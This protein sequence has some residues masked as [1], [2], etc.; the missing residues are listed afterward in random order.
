MSGGGG[1]SGPSQQTVTQTNLPEYARPYFE[2][3]MSRAEAVSNQPYQLY[4]GPR[5]ADFNADQNAAF[6]MARDLPGSYQPAM[7]TSQG[8]TT[9]ATL[10]MPSQYTAGEFQHQN[11]DQA[12]A[13]QYMNPYVSTVLDQQLARANTRFAEQRLDRNARAA[14][15]G[16]FGGYRQGVEEAMAE[17]DY[18]TQ[19]NEIEANAL[20]EAFK[21]AQ[22]QFN[23][24]R[25]A[26][27]SAFQANQGASQQQEQLRQ[28][29]LS[30][31]L[32][33]SQQLFNQGAGAQEA[34]L[35]SIQALRDIGLQQQQMDQA[36]LDL[37]QQ[38]FANQQNYDLNQLNFLNSILRGVPIT[39]S[40]TV[41]QYE[42]P[43]PY[44]Q[45]LGLGMNGLALANALGGSGGG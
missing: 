16:V 19:L 25:S 28:A 23:T 29:G 7:Q 45:L 2:R 6:D 38:D 34:D 9:L 10:G 35:R 44:S 4:Q 33:G 43:N 17:R 11:F 21:N 12:A 15:S 41:S 32:S 22:Q 14:R 24:D 20:M 13:D 37:A 42:N 40:T 1:S 18:N 8:L 26:G 3:M 36:S 30:G 5:I 31:L 39:S 27:L